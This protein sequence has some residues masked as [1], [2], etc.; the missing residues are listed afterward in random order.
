MPAENRHEKDRLVVKKMAGN[1]SRIMIKTFVK[2]ALKDA[3]NAPERCTR[4][5]VDMALHFSNGRFQKQFFKISQA[6]LS[7]EES[8]YYPLIEDVLKHMDKDK[9]IGFGMGIGY[10][11]CTYG[12]HIIRKQQREHNRHVQWYYPLHI[13]D[14][15]APE[16]FDKYDLI[17]HENKEIG[18][19]VYPISV[20]KNPAGLLPLVKKHSDCAFI[21]LCK[22]SEITEEF[23]QAAESADNLMIGVEG[24]DEARAICKMLRQ[25]RLVYSLYR[26]AQDA[27]LQ[28]ITSGNFFRYAAE[29]HAP[30]AAVLACNCSQETRD[31]IS[32]AVR[33]ARIGQQHRTIPVDLLSD[34]EMIQ[35]IIS[36]PSAQA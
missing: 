27:D 16:L 24:S 18:V 33:T 7:N 2:S 19:F 1:T 30:F 20:D 4:K 21:L 32:Q 17:L 5:L 26:N 25:H 12:A 36:T 3:D 35:S 11:G 28:D 8:P 31:A 10:N 14:G 23:A 15:N 34:A 29:L 9:L 13:A 6:M 22:T